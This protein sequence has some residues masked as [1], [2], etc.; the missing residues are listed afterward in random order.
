[1]PIGASLAADLT[2][3]AAV[4]STFMFVTGGTF[5]WAMSR[6]N[7]GVPAAAVT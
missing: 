4:Y 6:R 5:A 2:I 1:M 3:P 7:A